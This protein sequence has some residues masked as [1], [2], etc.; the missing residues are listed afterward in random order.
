MKGYVIGFIFIF[1]FTILANRA[2]NN[3]KIYLVFALLASISL[4]I[5][6]GFRDFSVVAARDVNMYV[7]PLLVNYNKFNIIEFVKIFNHLE[8]GF[9]IFCHVVLN[10]FKDGHMLLFFL[11][12]ICSIC[13][14]EYAYLRKDKC[15]IPIIV[16][17]YVLFWYI[18]FFILMRQGV[19]LCLVLLG[20]EYLVRKKFLRT[21]V[22]TLLALSFHSSAII[23]IPM[24]IYSYWF[25]INNK[26]SNKGKKQ[27]NFFITFFV[28]IIFIFY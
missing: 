19:A 27:I 12:F 5:I 16:M 1:I 26:L 11:Q 22:L 10:I 8:V 21:F 14:F 9:V 7:T 3:K 23:A 15:S 4:G 28:I 25:I 18:M 6:C 24:Y 13:I 20:N 17:I 2:R